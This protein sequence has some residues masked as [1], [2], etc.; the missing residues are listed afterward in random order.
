MILRKYFCLYLCLAA[1]PPMHMLS[2]AWKDVLYTL[3]WTVSEVNFGYIT[4][5]FCFPS[6][7][8]FT[9]LHNFYINNRAV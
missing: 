2:Q 5:T 6:T 3:S 8:K 4:A 1:Y 9:E 7:E